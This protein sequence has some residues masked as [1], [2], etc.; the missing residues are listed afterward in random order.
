MTT[1]YKDGQ[2]PIWIDVTVNRKRRKPSRALRFAELKVGDQLM[3]RP[4]GGDYG[5]HSTYYL[6]TDLWFDPVAGQHDETAGRMVGLVR[7]GTDGEPHGTK[8]STTLRGLASQQYHYS[9]IDYSAICK[10]K[11]E[12]VAA[13][14]LVGIGYGRVIRQRP[15]TPG[16]HL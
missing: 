1:I 5:R 8:S 6:V 9:S 14:E 16:H 10:A 15:K 4:Y 13:G 3:K 12:A 11:V 2:P 7:L